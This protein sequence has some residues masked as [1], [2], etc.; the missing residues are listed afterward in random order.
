MFALPLIL[1]TETRAASVPEPAR[2]IPADDPSLPGPRDPSQP[3]DIVAQ[4][5]TCPAAEGAPEAKP[6]APLTCQLPP[7]EGADAEPAAPETEGLQS[8]PAP[9][10]IPAEP[11]ETAAAGSKHGPKSHWVWLDY[12]RNSAQ[13]QRLAWRRGYPYWKMTY[14]WGGRYSCWGSHYRY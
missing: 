4:G 9:A 10:S 2:Q 11:V 13:C 7:D 12:V 1:G 6:G 14:E 5:A 8:V 3:G